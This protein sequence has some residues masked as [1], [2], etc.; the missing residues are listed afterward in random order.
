MLYHSH[1]MLINYVSVHY[2]MYCRIEEAAPTWQLTRISC[3]P[4][5]H[6]RMKGKQA[7]EKLTQYCSQL[8]GTCYLTRYS[9]NGKC[10][11]L[12]VLQNLVNS[13]TKR[14]KTTSKDYELTIYKPKTKGRERIVTEIRGTE[15]QFDTIYDLLAF[16]ERN[17]VDPVITKI[18]LMVESSKF[19][20]VV[21]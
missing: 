9:A 17:P 1:K 8:G 15:E 20:H 11:V 16:Y 18:G 7:K 6:G 10:Y 5:F 3:H 2:S 12:T 19:K 4:S 13:F 21:S 14:N